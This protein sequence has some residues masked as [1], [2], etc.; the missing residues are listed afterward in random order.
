MAWY[1]SPATHVELGVIHLNRT[2]SHHRVTTA[3]ELQPSLLLADGSDIHR[4]NDPLPRQTAGKTP[5]VMNSWFFNSLALTDSENLTEHMDA[6]LRQLE[7]KE[8]RLRKLARHCWFTCFT[9]HIHNR[10]GDITL[11]IDTLLRLSRLV[12]SSAISLYFNQDAADE[13]KQAY[14]I[15][16]TLTRT[17]A[18]PR[19][20]EKREYRFET[21]GPGFLPAADGTPH[22]PEM[23]FR[24]AFLASVC[25]QKSIIGPL[26]HD[27]Y[28]GRFHIFPLSSHCNDLLFKSELPR[29][30]AVADA[31]TFTLN[32]A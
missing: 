16:Y 29:L 20:Y 9:L 6:V 18:T 27:G 3:L 25:K 32:G 7:P 21:T 13:D 4:Y 30:R 24:R 15:Q 23:S 17:R 5:S 28:Q 14:R 26:I 19:P 31:I 10:H 2:L 12:S 22:S 8:R 1:E 11:N